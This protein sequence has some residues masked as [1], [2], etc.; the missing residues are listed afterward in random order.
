M[1]FKSRPGR[2]KDFPPSFTMR[3]GL[4]SVVEA[5]AR[6]PRIAVALGRAVSR[7]ESS[8][9]RY[10]VTVESGERHIA[11]TVAVATNPAAACTLLRPVAPEVGAQ[12]AR[13]GEAVVETLGFAVRTGKV[14]LP[15]SSFLV[16]R[17]D[18]FHSVVTRDYLPD[19]VWRS[20]VFHFKPG[21]TRD[22]KLRRAAGLLRLAPSD[23]EDVAERRTV[24]PSPGLGHDS[25]V[26]AIDR[27]CA[28]GQLCV[29]GN[30]FAGLSIGDCVERSRQEWRRVAAL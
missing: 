28:G 26:A 14:K 8:G 10:A 12:V 13:V 9:G 22:Q 21:Q 17:N 18:T 4:Q 1:L 5:I 6:L 11:R 23:L 20:F 7:V 3:N 16:P 30:W 25:I 19:P 24:L 27:L 15:V 2:R 29:T